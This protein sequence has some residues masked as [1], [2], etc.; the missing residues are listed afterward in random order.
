MKGLVYV[1]LTPMSRPATLA[2]LAS[3]PETCATAVV[4]AALFDELAFAESVVM[5]ASSHADPIVRRAAM[6]AISHLARLHKDVA[7][8]RRL[9][10]Q[11]RRGFEDEDREVRGMA[12]DAVDDI[13]VFVPNVTDEVS[14]LRRAAAVHAREA[15]TMKGVRILD[16]DPDR[17]LPEVDL[18]EI[19]DAIRADVET[20]LWT[21]AGG[22]SADALREASDRADVLLGS[23][24]L[25]L[26]RGVT[27]V[28]DGELSGA[29]YGEDEPWVRVRAVDGSAFDVEST[30]PSVLE[31]M[32]ARF[33]RVEDLPSEG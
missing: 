23:A 7:S 27:R 32:R 8:T 9:L 25:E 20:S 12:C 30:R 29:L 18:L 24:L 10:T 14:E 15:A 1:E 21:C 13:E 17:G 5:T 2:A 4:S 33:E 19:L 22:E 3:E 11:L 16:R 6:I 31:R 26:L 28:V